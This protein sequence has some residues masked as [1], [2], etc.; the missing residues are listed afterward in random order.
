MSG[1]ALW[2]SAPVSAPTALSAYG[3]GTVD[4]FV[5]GTLDQAVYRKSLREGEWT[6]SLSEYDYLG[7]LTTTANIAAVSRTEGRIDLFARAVDYTIY[8]IEFMES[9]WLWRSTN[10]ST[11]G[12]TEAISWASDRVD[13]FLVGFDGIVYN[14]IWRNSSTETSTMEGWSTWEWLGANDS[15]THDW[16]EDSLSIASWGRNRYDLFG[17]RK[18]DNALYHRVSTGDRQWEPD[19]ERLG[20]YC[21]SRP[22]V[23][24]PKEGQLYLFVRGG[25]QRIWYTLY[26]DSNLR[27]SEFAPIGNLTTSGEPHAVSWGPDRVDLFVCSNNGNATWHIAFDGSSWTEWESLGGDSGNSPK[28]V[29]KENGSLDVFV[30]GNSGEVRWSSFQEADGQWQ[31]WV[32]LGI[33]GGSPP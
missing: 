11:P 22:S 4:I 7:G 26:E 5:Q 6:P 21:T 1:T 24:C 9:D 16:K 31:P 28:A 20:G 18:V 3:K 15:M 23:V 8:H 25:D 13:A 17:V 32:D 19:F 27:W 2:Q 30:I 10:G 12:R 14:Q 29:A 33:P